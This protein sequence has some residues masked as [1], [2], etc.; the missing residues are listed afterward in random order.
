MLR[1]RVWR[2]S[3][4]PLVSWPPRGFSTTSVQ[5]RRWRPPL[6]DASKSRPQAAGHRHSRHL[7]SCR[8]CWWMPTT[9]GAHRR[10]RGRARLVWGQWAAQQHRAAKTGWQRDCR[11]GADLRCRKT[12]CPREKFQS[13]QQ[14]LLEELGPGLAPKVARSSAPVVGA[15]RRASSAWS[16][17]PQSQC[18][19][20]ESSRRR[21]RMRGGERSG[22]AR[23]WTS[24]WVGSSSSL[25][26]QPTSAGTCSWQSRPPTG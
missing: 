25:P 26:M 17:S 23:M 11:M 1:V 7:R 14:H 6:V 13:A 4:R 18:T 2:T 15:L 12:T 21:W 19:G 9:L 16:N 20:M 22:V 5:V 8:R 3:M 10:L 24:G